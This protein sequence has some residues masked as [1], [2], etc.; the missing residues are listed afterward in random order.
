[1]GATDAIAMPGDAVLAAAIEGH[2]KVGQSASVATAEGAAHRAEER[3]PGT[4][5]RW[6]GEEAGNVDLAVVH[7]PAMASP[8]HGCL[9]AIEEAIV[10]AQ[11]TNDVLDPGLAGEVDPASTLK[12]LVEPRFETAEEV[13]LPGEHDPIILNMCSVSITRRGRGASG[14]G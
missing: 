6:R 2:V 11:P 10:S 4:V 14:L 3:I 9:E 13:Q 12:R 7:D 5:V 8:T 1:M